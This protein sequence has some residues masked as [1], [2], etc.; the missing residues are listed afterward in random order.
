MDYAQ[1][2]DYV[3]GLIRYS[4]LDIIMKKKKM[5]NEKL[6]SK[7]QISSSTISALRYGNRDILKLDSYKLLMLSHGLNVKM[8]SLFPHIYLEKN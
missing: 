3:K 2:L 6:A 8:E 7:A 1:L 5:S 4:V